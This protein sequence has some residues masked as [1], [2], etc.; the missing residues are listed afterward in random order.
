MHGLPAQEVIDGVEVFRCTFLPSTL[1]NIF[2][3]A[4]A[5]YVSLGIPRII[6]E[7]KPDVIHIRIASGRAPI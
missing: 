3:A 6:R 7:F 1:P 4:R 5:G 2:H